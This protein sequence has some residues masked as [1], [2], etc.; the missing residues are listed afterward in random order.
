MAIDD[1][2][3][4]L[5][6]AFPAGEPYLPEELVAPILKLML[7]GYLTNILGAV[8]KRLNPKVQMQRAIET[9]KLLVAD[10]KDLKAEVAANEKDL[11]GLKEAV[12][13]AVRYDVAEFNDKKRERYVKII[14]ATL[15][16]EQQIDDLASYIQDVEQLGE[17]DIT[18]LKVLNKVMNKPGD[19]NVNL[20]SNIHPGLFVQ[21]RQE[22]AVQMAHAFGMKTD[23][24]TFSREEGYD[25]CNRLQAFGL[26]HELETSPRQVP[27]GD[28]CFR[29]S[30]RGLTLLKLIGQQVP[31]WDKYNPPENTK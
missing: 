25:A 21:R 8:C 12:Q 15:R 13:L 28:Y 5:D 2:Y 23:G 1:R 6:K 30:L 18:A 7:P 4:A 22:L 3:D 11:D 31:N 19:F 10:V 26:A 14:G 27:I 16:D 9:L 29:P 24:N 17:R 20:D